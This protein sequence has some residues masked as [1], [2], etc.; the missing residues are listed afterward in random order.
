MKYS[1]KLIK[2]S[3]PVKKN[4]KSSFWVKLFIRKLSFLFTFIL[5]NLNFSA[6]MASVLSVLV[7]IAGCAMFASSNQ[8]IY[9][10]G[11]I[12]INFWLVLDCVDGNIA[13]CHK[14]SSIY[15]EFID[16]LSGYTIL[17]F[18]YLSIGIHSY[19]QGGVI[20]TKANIFLIIIGACAS[21]FDILARIIHQKFQYTLVI[22]HKKQ[23]Q[24]TNFND[25]KFT[26]SYIR[27][28]VDKEIGIS[29]AFMPLLIVATLLKATDVFICFY[30]LFNLVALIIVQI[31][32]I[33]KAS[34]VNEKN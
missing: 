32:Y 34:I 16:A 26:L 33:K 5:I 7:A 1:Y 22:D 10:I 12:L 25:N 23:E 3:L 9:L 15:G 27:S 20:I 30:F 13:R 21:I 6:T 28:R 19:F 11:L 2:Q 17:S 18:V 24:P 31:T 14:S 4:S 29:G 8:I